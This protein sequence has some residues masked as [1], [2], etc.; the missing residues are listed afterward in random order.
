MSP[1]DL[2]NVGKET[3]LALP[4]VK[5]IEQ[6]GHTGGVAPYALDSSNADRLWQISNELIQ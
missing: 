3:D 4:P 1:D 6:G 2:A 5:T